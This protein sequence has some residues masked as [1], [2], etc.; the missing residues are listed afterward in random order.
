MHLS[1]AGFRQDRARAASRHR[2]PRPACRST[3]R[4][5]NS[6]MSWCRIIPA[7]ANPNARSGCA[8]RATSPRWH[9][10]LLADLGVEDVNLVGLGFGG[11]IAAEMVSQ[12]PRSLPPDGAGRPHGH[13]AARRRHLRPGDRFL[14]GLSAG[15][16]PQPRR[17]PPGLRPGRHRPTGTVGHLPRDVLPHRVETLHVQPDVAASARRRAHARHW[18]SGATTTRSCRSA[19]ATS[20]PKRCA[21][22]R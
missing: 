10:W 18:S 14:S 12:S 2:H 1:R 20:I 13:Q 19:P 3:I 9:T 4:W 7:G 8:T 22:R 6:S 16:L 5:R 21:T 15:R 11:W 17:V